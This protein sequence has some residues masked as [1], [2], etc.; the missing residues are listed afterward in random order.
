VTID[1]T[2]VSPVDLYT[3]VMRRMTLVLV[4]AA[5]LAGCGASKKPPPS[6][7]ANGQTNIADAAYRYAACMRT[8]GVSD[9]PDPQVSSQ[10]NQTS[11]RQMVPAGTAKSPAFKGAQRACASIMPGPGTAN[12]AEEAQQRRL[13]TLGLLSFAR[14]MRAH[15]VSSFPDPD[16]Q[17]QISPQALASAGIDIHLPSVIQAAMTCVPASHGVLTRAAVAQAVNGG[18]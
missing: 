4:A 7:S 14:C 16:A 17:G 6:S 8:H 5:A 1:V 11:V 12:P 2:G 18:G 10:G 15:A 3:R 9:F 13:R